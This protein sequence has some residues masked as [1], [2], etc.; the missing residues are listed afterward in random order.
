MLWFSQLQS[1]WGNFNEILYWEV[2]GPPFSSLQDSISNQRSASTVS[3]Q[4]PKFAIFVR[5]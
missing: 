1:F 3:N 5:N 4:H 2:L